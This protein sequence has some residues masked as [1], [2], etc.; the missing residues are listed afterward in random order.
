MAISPTR[1]PTLSVDM[2][3]GRQSDSQPGPCQHNTYCPGAG[4]LNTNRPSRSVVADPLGAPVGARS[5]TV[6]SGN[7]TLSLP[8][9]A[10]IIPWIG[11]GCDDCARIGGETRI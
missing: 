8:K 2:G 10:A 4:G 3:V 11:P 1:I 5:S 9:R 6:I 7:K